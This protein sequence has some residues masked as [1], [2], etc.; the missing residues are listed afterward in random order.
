MTIREKQ[1][2]EVLK[3]H[4]DDIIHAPTA[5][6]KKY[7]SSKRAFLTGSAA[8]GNQDTVFDLDY[9][10]KTKQPYEAFS[11]FIRGRYGIYIGDYNESDEFI[12][13]YALSEN[14]IIYNF[15]FMKE[16]EYYVWYE[17]TT[18]MLLYVTNKSNLRRVMN[19]K[20]RRVAVFEDYKDEVREELRTGKL[21]WSSYCQKQLAVDKLKY[22]DK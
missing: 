1:I 18:R 20:A 7:T 11:E 6:I 2:E 15:L 10:V 13:V 21:A 17:A 14:S 22:L 9:C 4:H 19:D 3:I 16:E 8:F 5:A 12:S